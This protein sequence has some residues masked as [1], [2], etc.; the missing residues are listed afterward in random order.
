MK[1]AM[2]SLMFLAGNE[3]VTLLAMLFLT[4]CLMADILKARLEK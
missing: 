3:I 1:Y 4:G 2:V